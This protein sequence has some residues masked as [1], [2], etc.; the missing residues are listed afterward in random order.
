MYYIRFTDDIAEDLIRGYSYD[1]R[2]GSK[3]DGLC[4]WQFGFN[5]SPYASVNEVMGEARKFAKK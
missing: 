1:F 4:A 3:Q 5:L 2:D